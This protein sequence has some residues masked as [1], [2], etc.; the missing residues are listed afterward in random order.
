MSRIHDALKKAEQERNAVPFGDSALPDSESLT[1]TPTRIEQPSPSSGGT[2]IGRVAETLSL[3]RSAA[4]PRRL[5]DFIAQCANPG[6]HP[7]PNLSV[8]S[9]VNKN[10]I[11]AE[12]FR[13]LRSRLYRLRSS[14]Q[15]STI[16]V[17]SALAGEGKTFVA[18]NLAQAIVRQPDRR[19]LLIDGDLRCARLHVALGAPPTPGL[20]D[21]LAEEADEFAVM[22]RGPEPNLCLIAGGREVAN[23]SELLSNGRLKRLLDRVRPMFDWVIIDSPPCVAVADANVLADFCDGA[24]LV[25]RAGSTPSELGRRAAQELQNRNVLG[26][27]LNGMEES[28]GYGTYYYPYGNN[29]NGSEISA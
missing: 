16:L 17:T 8:F 27:V 18:G 22:Q 6:W 26:V 20:S 21:Y 19:V 23:P 15:L 2:S 28:D 7:A 3:N 11:G 25:V 12:Q 9:G 10:S 24:L 5:E 13:T 29:S 1:A 14:Q 4:V